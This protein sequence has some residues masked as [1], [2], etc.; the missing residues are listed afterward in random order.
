MKYT[1]FS[2]D[3][4]EYKCRYGYNIKAY[5]ETLIHKGE[6]LCLNLARQDAKN[7]HFYTAEYD[8]FDQS[9]NRISTVTV[10]YDS[11]KDEYQS[12]IS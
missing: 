3:E 8:V 5:A 2:E 11:K 1:F 4:F 9:R 6:S 7:Q 10:S 12:K